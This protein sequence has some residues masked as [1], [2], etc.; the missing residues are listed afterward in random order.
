VVSGRLKNRRA[1]RRRPSSVIQY[2]V[3]WQRRIATSLQLFEVLKF[4]RVCCELVT[5]IKMDG[6]EF[7]ISENKEDL[8]HSSS[9]NQ[10]V[11]EQTYSKHELPGKLRGTIL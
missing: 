4:S 3:D 11:V 5:D 10:Y 9:P 8:L 1:R 7:V 6:L 2:S